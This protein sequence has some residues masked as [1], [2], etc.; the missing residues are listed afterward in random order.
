MA[1]RAV[2]V[3][4]CG[5]DRRR[6]DAPFECLAELDL[7]RP[8]CQYDCQ[9]AARAALVDRTGS[10]LERLPVITMRPTA[11]MDV[12]FLRFAIPTLASRDT[13]IEGPGSP[14]H[15]R[16]RARRSLAG[17]PAQRR[18]VSARGRADGSH[19][20]ASSRQSLR[21]NLRRCPVADRSSADVD[22][23]LHPQESRRLCARGRHSCG[24]RRM[25][26]SVDGLVPVFD[27]TVRGSSSEGS[28]M[29]GMRSAMSF[30]ASE[31]QL[32]ARE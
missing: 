29:F 16:E 30:L 25:R 21:P 28:M 1:T 22:R 32:A 20:V 17:A 12:F 18:P 11:F 2:E 6:D 23:G 15:L 14:D 24:V 31:A 26:W 9:S 19:G 7:T 3:T 10:S 8:G 13:L 4:A 27:A 5:L